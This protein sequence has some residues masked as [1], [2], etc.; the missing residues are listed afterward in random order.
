M[1]P[2][3][4]FIVAALALWF[5]L[6]ASS[7]AAQADCSTDDRVQLARAGYGKSDIEALCTAPASIPMPA[8]PWGILAGEGQAGW[9]QWCVTPQGRCP[10]NPML[11]PYQRGTP[12]NCYMP[13]G[14]YGGV[15]E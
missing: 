2:N 15:S 5:F 11:L 4:F 14:F 10:L 1:Q 8:Q 3:R 12:C 9:V 13:W 7:E 6:G